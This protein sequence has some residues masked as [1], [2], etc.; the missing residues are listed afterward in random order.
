M[1]KDE[2]HRTKGLVY[3]GIE[4]SL[5]KSTKLYQ[6][7]SKLQEEVH[8]FAIEYHKSLRKKDMLHSQL[9]DIAGVGEVRRRSLIKHFKDIAKIKK[10]T[11]EELQEVEGINRKVAEVIYNHYHSEVQN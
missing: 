10:A 6:L 9:E 8:R 7:V 2:K 5:N 1:V 4:I 11:I 3:E